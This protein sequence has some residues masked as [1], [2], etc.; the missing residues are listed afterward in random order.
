MKR[1]SSLLVLTTLFLAFTAAGA[2]AHCEI[3]CG[4]YDDQLRVQLMYEHC[5][6]IEK[7]MT[8]IEGLSKQDPINYNQLVRWV[9]NKE[10]HA[11]KIQD[12]VSQYFLH[13]RIKFDTDKYEEKLAVL[14]KIL[15]Y[16]MRCKQTVDQENIEKIRG[17]LKEFEKLYF[18]HSH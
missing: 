6:T 5:K 11:A 8:Q 3:P 10:M 17:L 15:V 12:I 14:H 16:A 2:F 9:N 1:F 7:S 18:G 4:I 13:Q